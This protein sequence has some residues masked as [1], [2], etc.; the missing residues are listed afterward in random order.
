[1]LV[2]GLLTWFVPRLGM[3]GAPLSL[4]IGEGVNSLIQAVWVA[5]IL[6][7][8]ERMAVAGAGGA[9]GGG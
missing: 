1:V 6:S 9:R 5:R 7:A 4:L 2:F 3:P 8:H